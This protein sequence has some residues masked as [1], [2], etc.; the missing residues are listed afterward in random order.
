MIIVRRRAWWRHAPALAAYVVLSLLALAPLL[1]RFDSVIA[2]GPVA[3]VDGWQNVWNLWWVGRALASG[4]NPFHTNLLYYPTGVDLYLQ[5]LNIS[6]GG[7]LWPVTRLWGPV[8]AYNAA[9]L[10]ALVLSALG[11]YLFALQVARHRLAAFI[12]GLVFAFSPYHLTKI[13]DG[14]LE[15]ISTQ[16]L[17]FYALFLLR[18]VEYRRWRDA[19]LAAM[20]L[21]LIGYTSWYYLLFTAVYSVLFVGVW[22]LAVRG[23]AARR[24]LLARAG[25]VALGGIVLLLPVLLPAY[26]TSQLHSVSYNPSD[27]NDSIVLH[28]AN[29]LDFWLPSALHPLWGA[30]SERVSRQWH[31]YIFGWNVSLSYTALGLAVAGVALAWRAAWRWGVLALAM[32]V[33]ALGPRLMIGTWATDL[34]LPYE[35]LLQLPVLAIARRPSHFVVFTTLL[36]APLAALGVRALLARWGTARQS[37]V[38]AGVALLLALELLPPRWPLHVLSVH[39]FY[40]T[41]PPSDEALLELPPPY[42]S[43]ERLQAQIMHGRPILGGFVSRPP[44]YPFTREVP[45]LR[46]LWRMAP[47]QDRMLAAT[48][49]DVLSALHFYRISHVLV[50]WDDVRAERRA[51]LEAALA[52]ALPNIQPSY[53]DPKLSVYRMP[54]HTPESFAFF[55]GAGW[56]EEEGT[57]EERFRWMAGKGQITLVNPADTLRPVTVQLRVASYQESRPLRITLDGYT[58]VQQ[59]LTPLPERLTLTLLLPPGEHALVLHAPT[60][61]EADAAR[62]LS[63]VLLD[64]RLH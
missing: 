17:A 24:A 35:A 50:H 13:W 60:S 40:A 29:L 46:Q 58:V 54:E 61:L 22:L 20:I 62:A 1:P 21:A 45:G 15:L 53:A 25:L 63:I 2:G 44:H 42:E 36:L 38:F 27:P 34:P 28:S 43:S 49:A 6:N 64:M 16:W 10:L 47:D 30:A 57:G 41:L 7:L 4:H 31:S 59:D 33:L 14:Q 3:N 11:G 5:T 23:W 52:Q 32:L 56:Y 26:G 12:G 19:L 9:V 18:A 37:L 8:A 48:P 39:P 51:G 55:S